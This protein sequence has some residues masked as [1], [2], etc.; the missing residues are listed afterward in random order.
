MKLKAV[1]VYES[2]A[3]ATAAIFMHPAGAVQVLPVHGK[4]IILT[5]KQAEEL[6]YEPAGQKRAN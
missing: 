2:F 1:K 5:N 4:W 6:Y 3:E